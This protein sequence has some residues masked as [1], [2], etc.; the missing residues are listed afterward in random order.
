MGGEFVGV[1]IVP[2]ENHTHALVH[3]EEGVCVDG[4]V[5]GPHRGDGGCGGVHADVVAVDVAM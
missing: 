2:L 3:E 4:N 5:L 1:H